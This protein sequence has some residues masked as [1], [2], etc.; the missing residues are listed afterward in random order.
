MDQLRNGELKAAFEQF[1]YA[2]AAGCYFR[3]CLQRLVA[4]LPP[5]VVGTDIGHV[6]T[7]LKFETSLEMLPIF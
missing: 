6:E 5:N 3:C 1:K 4:R 7:E 2:E